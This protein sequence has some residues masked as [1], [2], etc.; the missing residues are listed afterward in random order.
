MVSTGGSQA[1]ACGNGRFLL[2]P[3]AGG[4]EKRI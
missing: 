2:A 1:T 4:A 3:S